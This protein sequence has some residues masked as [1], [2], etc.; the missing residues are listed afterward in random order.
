MLQEISTIFFKFNGNIKVKDLNVNCTCDIEK[1]FKNLK[2]PPSQF[3]KN[4][5]ILGNATFWD[6]E[7]GVVKILN[8]VVT[9]QGDNEITGRVRQILLQN[10][11]KKSMRA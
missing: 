7:A 3:W 2:N 5:V 4:V 11:I 8:N 6:Q 10:V 1:A 9:S